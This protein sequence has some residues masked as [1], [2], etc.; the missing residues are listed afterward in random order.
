MTARTITALL[1]INTLNPAS[2]D[3]IDDALGK[4]IDVGLADAADTVEDDG[5]SAPEAAHIANSLDISFPDLT[6]NTFTVLLL[7]PEWAC[8]QRGSTYLAC[9]QAEHIEGAVSAA[10]LEAWESER[11]PTERNHPAPAN[12]LEDFIVLIALRGQH[13]NLLVDE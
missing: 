5:N 6:E 10:R 9:V 11:P 3:K 13:A 8:E 1:T 2:L 4:I 12:E 7:R